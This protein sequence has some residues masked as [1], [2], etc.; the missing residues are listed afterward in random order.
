[1]EIRHAPIPLYSPLQPVQQPARTPA[2]QEAGATT[3]RP[4][5]HRSGLTEYIAHGELVEENDNTD[6]GELIRAARQ[7]RAESTQEASAATGNGAS[8]YA[9]RALTAYQA[10]TGA[11][12][13]GTH[14]GLDE[15]V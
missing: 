3:G 1:M 8:S 12:A 11:A 2:P 15:I 9:T 6:Y 4:P 5:E 13:T 7:Q 14:A 10:N